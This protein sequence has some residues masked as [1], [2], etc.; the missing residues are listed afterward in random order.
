MDEYEMNEPV[1]PAMCPN[2]NETFARVH[3]LFSYHI[4]SWP[5]FSHCLPHC[6]MCQMFASD[7][8]YNIFNLFLIGFLLPL[9]GF[10]GLIGNGLSAFIYSRQ[11]IE[12]A[13]VEYDVYGSTFV[14]GAIVGQ[15][16]KLSVDSAIVDN[17]TAAGGDL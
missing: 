15:V 10:C 14:Y 7:A 12:Y 5:N 17:V 4:I 9:V 13:I 8:T 16:Q 2:S 3:M 1:L 6:G 11:V